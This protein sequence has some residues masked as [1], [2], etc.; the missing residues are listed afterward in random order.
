MD[1]V[2]LVMCVLDGLFSGLLMASRV[3]GSLFCSLR[4][5]VSSRQ[6][7]VVFLTLRSRCVCR[8]R[9]LAALINT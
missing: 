9:A 5:A 1:D 2:R 3:G 7:F 4:V 6:A 8:M